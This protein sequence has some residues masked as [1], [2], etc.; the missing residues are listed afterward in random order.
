MG[1]GKMSLFVL[2]YIL[3]VLES[4]TLKL[5]IVRGL[6][7]VKLGVELITRIDGLRGAIGDSCPIRKVE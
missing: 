1:D 5:E 3:D 6:I 2:I 7:V 4:S